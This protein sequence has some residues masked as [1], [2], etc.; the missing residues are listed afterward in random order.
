[1]T[2]TPGLTCSL[3][4]YHDPVLILLLSCIVELGSHAAGF[5]APLFHL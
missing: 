2:T 4:H 5:S 1:L 3:E